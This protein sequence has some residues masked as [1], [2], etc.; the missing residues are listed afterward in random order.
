VDVVLEAP[1]GS[2]SIL[3]S[4]C[5]SFIGVTDVTLTFDQTV[6]SNLPLTSKLTSGTFLP[7]T[8]LV[9]MP[10]LPAVPANETVP[11]APPESPFPY[12][13][14]L[15]TF[16]GA[17]PNGTWS[18]WAICDKAQDSGYISNGWILTLSTGAVVENDSD[19]E[20]T[21]ATLPSA[22]TEGTLLTYY[23]TVTNF[24]PSAATNV[25]ITDDLPSQVTYVSNSC[26]CG[27]LVG[28][29]LTV[30]LPSLAVG[31]GTAFN[32]VVMP[33]ALGSIT[34]TVTALAEEPDPN[35]NNTVTTTSLVSLPSADVGVNLTGSPS[36]TLVGSIVVFSIEVFNN[37][38]STASNVTAIA[39]LG[40]A[41]VVVT[42]GI[43]VTNGTVTNV[44]G[45]ITW[46]IGDMA[47]NFSGIGPT[48]T[49]TTE[50]L[51]AGSNLVSVT[52]SS[53]VYDPLK[54]NNY[55]AVKIEV[56][57]PMLTISGVSPSF[58]LT[59]SA[60]ATNY[61]LEGATELPPSG[62]WIRIPEPP[63][64]NGVYTYPLP[65]ANGYHFFQL[66]TQLP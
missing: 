50:A 61:W 44:N 64:V 45:T 27:T 56:D 11:V 16:L 18:L 15:S 41:F 58:E 8:N 47:A 34:N 55:A 12:A 51:I 53:P 14:N 17:S 10:Q 24:G 1:N 30:S 60:L 63:L 40:P 48:M 25:V 23:V 13:A 28:D 31:A 43:T 5:G 59:W 20:V 39:V 54:G 38:P 29:V 33:T 2:N 57:Q 32:I 22:A 37:G 26:N 62:M 65:G 7:T 36:P 42:N 3:M 21:V 6:S 49:V 35:I 9:E 46:T 19:L 66:E 4:H 52:A